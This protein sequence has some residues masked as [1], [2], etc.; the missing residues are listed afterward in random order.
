[1]NYAFNIGQLLPTFYKSDLSIKLQ[2]IIHIFYQCP[3][4]ASPG[5]I[6]LKPACRLNNSLSLTPTT[7]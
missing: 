6:D 4:A 7:L 3:L 5:R 1:M 2:I